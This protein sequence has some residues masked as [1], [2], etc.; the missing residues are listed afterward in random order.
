M[1]SIS[2]MLTRIRNGLKVRKAEVLIP[3]SR[4]QREIA[5]VLLEEGYISD[6]QVS[7]SPHPMIRLRLKY[8][9]LGRPVIYGLRRVSKSSRRV[10]RSRSE[11]PKVLGGL[12]IA[13]ISTSKGVLTDR[14]ARQ[15]GLGGEV[16]CEVW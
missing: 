14:E 9:E 16:L 13:I 7:E 6:C 12:G 11:L 3:Y 2:D 8:D 1:D 5:R 15:M 10:Y 4:V